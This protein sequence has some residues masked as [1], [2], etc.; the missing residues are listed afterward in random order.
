MLTNAIHLPLDLGK[1]HKLDRAAA[2]AVGYGA[3][4]S[5]VQAVLDP[6][7]NTP[8]LVHLLPEDEAIRVHKAL[9]FHERYSM[10]SA[11]FGDELARRR[12]RAA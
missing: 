11:E 2:Y 12:L 1:L 8:A 4:L 3:G 7:L 10:G 5:A 9:T 6:D